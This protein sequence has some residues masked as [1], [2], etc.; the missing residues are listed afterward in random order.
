MKINSKTKSPPTSVSL[1]CKVQWEN[2][3]YFVVAFYNGKEYINPET[4]KTVRGTV[5]GWETLES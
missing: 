2:E 4:H 5:I 3:T 1:I